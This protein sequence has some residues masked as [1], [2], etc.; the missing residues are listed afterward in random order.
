MLRVRHPAGGVTVGGVATRLEY[1]GSPVKLTYDH[2]YD[3]VL[4]SSDR[5][6]LIDATNSPSEVGGAT[7][8]GST[9]TFITKLIDML[10]A[11]AAPSLSSTTNR[12]NASPSVAFTSVVLRSVGAAGPATYESV[13]T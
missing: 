12:S 6:L 7:T 1:C 4:N 8:I 11:A 10:A 3:T 13:G 2:A 9:S 5:V